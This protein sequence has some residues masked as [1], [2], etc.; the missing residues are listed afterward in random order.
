[1]LFTS[2]LQQ[3][4]VRLYELFNNTSALY[5]SYQNARC[6]SINILRLRKR[7]PGNDSSQSAYISITFPSPGY[8]SVIPYSHLHNL[9]KLMF[10]MMTMLQTS[11]AATST[12]GSLAQARRGWS[13]REQWRCCERRRASL[14]HQYTTNF[15]RGVSRN[16]GGEIL[17]LGSWMVNFGETLDRR[18]SLGIL[19]LRK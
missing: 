18:A 17:L 7:F 13:R 14:I 10:V 4:P 2:R 6:S 3:F 15:S 9:F 1:M 5:E 11:L 12:L 16:Q 8:F 19:L